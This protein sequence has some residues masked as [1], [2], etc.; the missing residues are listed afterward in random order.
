MVSRDTSSA[1]SRCWSRVSACCGSCKPIQSTR[2]RDS[3]GKQPTP[4]ANR[5][6]GACCAIARCIAWA[7][8]SMR[9]GSTSPRNFS[10]RWTCVGLTQRQGKAYCCTTARTSAKHCWRVTGGVI[11][12]KVRSMGHPS[13]LT[14]S[15][16]PQQK[17]HTSLG[18]TASQEIIQH[19][20]PSPGQPFELGKGF[21]NV[22]QAKQP[23]ADHYRPHRYW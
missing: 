6:K 16:K 22:K 4:W 13:C 20:T 15:D 11:A 2:G 23:K 14:G 7:M 5:G 12:I 9:A 17:A 18:Q 10:V 1:S 21:Q 8:V 19:N 3:V